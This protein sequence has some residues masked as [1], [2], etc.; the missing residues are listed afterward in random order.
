MES[1]FAES[2]GTLEQI[3]T[4]F[5]QLERHVGHP[6]EVQIEDTI[7]KKLEELNKVFERVEIYV[8]KEPPARRQ[9]SRLKLNQMKYDASHLNA[10]LKTFQRRRYARDREHTE[11]EDLLNRRFTTNSSEDTSISM[12]Y[13]LQHNTR[14]ENAN[15]GLDDMLDQGHNILGNL[16]DQRETLK[17]TRTKMLNFLNTLGLSNSVMN[18]IERRAYQDKFVLYGGMLVTISVMFLIYMYFI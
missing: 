5:I 17:R 3:N 9:G 15:R 13:S 7:H 1:L 11:R 16:R 4:L 8:M 14:L 6:D 10:S 18:L 12:D 2:H